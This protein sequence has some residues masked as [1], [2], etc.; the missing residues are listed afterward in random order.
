MQTFKDK[1]VLITGATGFIGSHFARLAE[2]NGARVH[3]LSRKLQTGE[4]PGASATPSSVTWHTVDLLDPGAVHTSFA[5]IRPD[6]VY[7]LA[8]HPVAARTSDQVLPAFQANLVTT[9][10]LLAAAHDVGCQRVVLAGS[11]EQPLAGAGGEP[12]SSPY[13]LSKWAAAA[14]AELYHRLYHTPVMVC[15]IF[16]VYGPG[17]RDLAKLIPYTTLALLRGESPKLSSGQ[18][19][20]DWIFVE[21]VAEGLLAAGRTGG[22]N[23]ATVDLGSG[24]L[25][26][27]R[28]LV[29]LLVELTGSRARPQF[30]AL[31]DRSQEAVSVANS[32]ETAAQ[33]GWTP[34]TSLRDGLA[35]TVAWCRRLIESG[36]T[37]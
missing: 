33:L 18:R 22:L 24:S 20:V 5:E 29:E 12:A 13:A 21:D 16:M 10:H 14:Y 1:T 28:D 34:R 2:T 8:G 26:A 32:A 9:V 37:A 35:R 36:V 25:V 30:G 31:P 17:Q 6:F 27:I 4:G 3:A 23:G 15:R 19:P 7:H 11:L